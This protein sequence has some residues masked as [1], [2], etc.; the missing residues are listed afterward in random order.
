MRKVKLFCAAFLTLIIVDSCRKNDLRATLDEVMLSQQETQT[1]EILTDI[2]LIADEAIGQNASV[3]KSASLENYFYLNSCAILTL[4]TKSSP[5]VLT[6]DFGTSCTGKDGKIRSGKITI[7][8][9]A[10][11]SFPSI[12]TKTFENYYVDKKKIDG[13]IVKTIQRDFE[14]KIR[15]ANSKEDITIQLADQEGSVHRLADLTRQYQINSAGN[16][17][18]SVVKSWGVV[19]LTRLSGEKVTKTVTASNPLVY[20]T[21]CH[22]IVSGVV[23]FSTGSGHSW[24]INFGDGSCD[25]K[26][27][28]TIGTK[29]KEITIR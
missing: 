6:I 7:T 18:N 20:S 17:D 28:L 13:T 22:H 26:A 14:N 5:Q 21:S 2:D 9:T 12:R 15:T 19:E 23:S 1:D 4:N 24:S 16:L 10:F 25:N 11:N 27:I 3:L 29:T 8:S